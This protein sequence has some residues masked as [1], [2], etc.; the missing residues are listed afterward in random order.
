MRNRSG[1]VSLPSPKPAR[2]FVVTLQIVDP[3]A[4]LEHILGREG[5]TGKGRKLVGVDLGRFRKGRKLANVEAVGETPSGLE[6]AW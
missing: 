2:L 5:L 1:S 4:G 6:A 3:L